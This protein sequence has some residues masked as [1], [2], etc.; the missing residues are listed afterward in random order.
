MLLSGL[1]IS[2][3][4][5]ASIGKENSVNIHQS[6]PNTPHGRGSRLVIADFRK[7]LAA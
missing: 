2:T 4:V 6:A 7:N 1:Y 3:I 5:V